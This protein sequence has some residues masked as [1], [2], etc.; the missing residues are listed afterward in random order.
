MCHSMSTMARLK[1]MKSL[2]LDP[3]LL[4]RV[5]A[6]IDAQDVPPKETNVFETALREFLEKREKGRK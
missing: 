2:A 6:W 5:R 1:K 3:T 4:K